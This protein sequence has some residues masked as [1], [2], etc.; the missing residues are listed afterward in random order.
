MTEGKDR[1][2]SLLRQVAGCVHQ[3]DAFVTLAQTGKKLPDVIG[4][5][6]VERLYG[7]RQ[8]YP[9]IFLYILLSFGVNGLLSVKIHNEYAFSLCRQVIGKHS[10][11]RSLTDTALLIG[12]G[13]HDIVSHCRSCY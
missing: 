10:A 4:V 1:Y 11:E 3:H 9:S 7:I 5:F 13:D 2:Q 8:T 12:K 6:D